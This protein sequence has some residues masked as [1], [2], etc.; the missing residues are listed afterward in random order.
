MKKVEVNIKEILKII[1]LMEKVF[2]NGE[3]IILFMMV[4]IKM[5][6]KMEMEIIQIIILNFLVILIMENH[7]VL[8]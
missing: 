6:K 1:Y 3:K 7:M 4:N 5:G 2:L 8:D